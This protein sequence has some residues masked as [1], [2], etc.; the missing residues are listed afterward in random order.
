[1]DI[2]AA[3]A[4]MKKEQGFAEK[5]GMILVHNGVARATSRTGEPVI[6]LDVTVN[7]EHVEVLRQEYEQRPGIFRVVVEAKS[8]HVKPTDDLLFIIV[9]GDLRENVKAVLAE[10]LDRVKAEAISK[11]EHAPE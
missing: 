3:I 11:T 5:V 8:G 7:Q 1:M 10:L 6:S 2:S 4:A 9:A